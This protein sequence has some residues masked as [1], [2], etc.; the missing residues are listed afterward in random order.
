MNLRNSAT[1][2]DTRQAQA[3]LLRLLDTLGESFVER[4]PP[5]GNGGVRTLQVIAPEALPRLQFSRL[6]F[7]SARLPCFFHRAALRVAALGA[8][9]LVNLALALSNCAGGEAVR[10]PIAFRG[11]VHSVFGRR[12]RYARDCRIAAFF[13]R[14]RRLRI[15]AR[16]AVSA[17]KIRYGMTCG[18]FF[19]LRAY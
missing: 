6:A 7:V 13:I 8:G 16:R 18:L 12:E 3:Q 1:P 4:G 11:G 10:L 15:C 9:G 19:G 2:G 5:G 14:K 17:K